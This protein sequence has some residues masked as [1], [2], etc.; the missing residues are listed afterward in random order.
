MLVEDWNGKY[1]YAKGVPVSRN[2][3]SVSGLPAYHNDPE[4]GYAAHTLGFNSFSIGL[5]VCG[6]RGAVDGRPAGEVDP[7]PSPI[8]DV[9]MRG[10]V[11]LTAHACRLYNLEPVVEQ[12]FLH[13]EAESVHGVE[14]RGK[15]DLQWL[16]DFTGTR[17]S[18][19][20]EIRRRI[21]AKMREQGGPPPEEGS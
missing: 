5:C 12:V 8:T 3:Q 18:Y 4:R 1:R 16:P 9:Q 19:G 20:P 7:G 13:P 17:S 2:M 11:A 6:M 21:V 15:W 14:Q 10:L